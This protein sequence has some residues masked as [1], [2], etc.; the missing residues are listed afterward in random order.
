MLSG[1]QLIVFDKGLH[2]DDDLMAQRYRRDWKTLDHSPR[3]ERVVVGG[4]RDQKAIDLSL[5]IRSS[6][7][8]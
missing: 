6:M 3:Q 1:N 2:N 5:L 4:Y 8:G 7:G